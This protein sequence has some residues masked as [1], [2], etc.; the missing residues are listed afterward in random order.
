MMMMMGAEAEAEAEAIS[1]SMLFFV[2]LPFPTASL[3][4]YLCYTP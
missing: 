2:W 3:G 4:S 1:K